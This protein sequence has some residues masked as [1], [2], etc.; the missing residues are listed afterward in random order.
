MTDPSPRLARWTTD[1]TVWLGLV[2]LA[3]GLA[4][5]A[6][7][8]GPYFASGA[9]MTYVNVGNGE[10]SLNPCAGLPSGFHRQNYLPFAQVPILMPAAGN[11][12]WI[13]LW[14][15]LPL[16]VLTWGW[17]TGGLAGWWTVSRRGLLLCW[18]SLSVAAVSLI[19]TVARFGDLVW[20]LFD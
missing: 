11:L 8:P 12:F 3:L 17:V 2:G 19:L 9:Q 6:L 18:L 5:L 14:L 13:A 16:L 10:Y 20:W 15:G 1:K 7:V 4:Y